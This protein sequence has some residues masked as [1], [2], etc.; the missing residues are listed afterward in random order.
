[1]LRIADITVDP[2][3]IL[4]PLA[5]YTDLPFRLLCRE[6][7]AGLCV[8]EMISCHGLVYG[9]QKTLAMLVSDPNE[10]PVAFQLFGSDLEIMGKAAA[11]LARFGPDCIDINMGCP[12][13]KV[14]KRG[15]GAALMRNPVLAGKIIESVRKHSALPVTVK[16]RSGIDNS[17][18]TA[19]S[20]ARIAESA[21][22]SAIIIHGR[23]WAQG[24]TGKADWQIISQVKEAVSIP[25][26]GNGD[27][28]TYQDGILMM[29]QTG[30][31][32]VMIGRGALGNPWVFK[33]SGRPEDMPS[34]MRGV[35]RHL[36][37]IDHCLFPTDRL[38]G[39]IKNH[40]GRYFKLL[41]GSSNFRKLV[42][43][44]E[45]YAQLKEK[46]DSLSQKS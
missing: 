20:F 6:Y 21:G 2:P 12:V 24:F 9:Q 38:L 17:Q 3:F 15:A 10:H 25:V 18:L 36:E 28:Q 19:A 43:E 23:T 44:S 40:I 41:P 27:I 39:L 42:Y 8:S 11:I 16:I 29:E 37:L 34:M 5:G 22:A 14:T 33:E 1:M 13:P 26:I 31:D 45:S 35:H 4:A 30:C 32:G 46:L 7:G